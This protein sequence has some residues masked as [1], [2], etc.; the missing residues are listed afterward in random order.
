M[1]SDAAQYVGDAE[2]LDTLRLSI[3]ALS[4][5]HGYRDP[6]T[7]EHQRRTAE[8]AAAIGERLGLDRF[9]I[10]VIR[11]AAIVHDIGKIGVPAEILSKAGRLSEPEY[12]IVKTHCAIGHA[13]LGQLRAPSAVA[14]VTLQH[15]E[16]LD[17][18]G[19]PGGLSGQSILIEAR[20]V[21]VA[22]VFDA[23][24]SHR[25]YRPGRPADFVLGELQ[26]MSGRLLDPDAVTACQRCI[27]AES[28]VRPDASRLAADSSTTG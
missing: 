21:A 15:H 3:A 24:T 8:L 17:G 1:L 7:V 2:L 22:D 12:A 13:I 16:R 9:K 14:E 28:A 20:I 19:Y 26:A 18:S 5:T 10:E 23:M 6:F 11:L 27:L 25:P 4:A